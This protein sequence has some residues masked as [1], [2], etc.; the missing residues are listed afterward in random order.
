M[1]PEI[2]E[3]MKAAIV[4]GHLGHSA[5]GI[6]PVP[7][8]ER[9]GRTGLHAGGTHLPVPYAPPLLLRGFLAPSDALDAEGAFFHDSL[10]T[11]RD[12]RIELFSQ[13]L[14]PHGVEPIELSGD[15]RTIVPAIAH[16]D[17]AVVH[18]GVEPVG[19]M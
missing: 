9:R 11:N 16:A 6:V 3:E 18:L 5:V 8:D 15:V 12:V 10:L 4:L 1:G 17:A 19:G 13:R 7:E 2:R 14:V